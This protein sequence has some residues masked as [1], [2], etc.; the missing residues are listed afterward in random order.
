MSLTELR[1]SFAEVDLRRGQY[2]VREGRVLWLEL[3]EH[4]GERSCIGEVRGSRRQPYRVHVRVFPRNGLMRLESNC[5]CP[6][7]LKC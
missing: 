3:R 6:V 1:A 5:S 4:A 2:Y 7:Q